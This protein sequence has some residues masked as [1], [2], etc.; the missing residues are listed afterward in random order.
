[1]VNFLTQSLDL[2]SGSYIQQLFDPVQTHA[3]YGIT[4]S[5]IPN[6]KHRLTILGAK[7]FRNVK[8]VNSDF[9]ILCFSAKSIKP[10]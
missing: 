6:L 9:R 5:D 4:E 10:N 7:R 8:C 3:V 2:H 1:M